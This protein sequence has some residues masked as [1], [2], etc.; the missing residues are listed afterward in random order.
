[1]CGEYSK[2]SDTEGYKVRRWT[3]GGHRV[4]KCV[5]D[6]SGQTARDEAVALQSPPHF[7]SSATT[8]HDMTTHASP[9]LGDHDER[10]A[11]FEADLEALI[12]QKQADLV[13]LKRERNMHASLF[14]LF[15]PEILANIIL[16]V[17][18]EPSYGY[19]HRQINNQS[20]LRILLVCHRFYEIALSTPSL[21]SN[22]VCS[23]GDDWIRLC[24]ARSKDHPL[25]LRR[26]DAHSSKLLVQ[27]REAS[28]TVTD[29]R[30]CASVSPHLKVLT[31]DSRTDVKTGGSFLGGSDI[32]LVH[33][34][35]THVT[36]LQNTPAMPLLRRLTLCSI[37]T[38]GGLSSLIRFIARAPSVEDLFIEGIE[39]KTG[40]ATSIRAQSPIF[41]PHLRTLFLQGRAKHI[42]ACMDLLPLP[43]HSLGVTSTWEKD[44]PDAR[45]DRLHTLCLDFMEHRHQL[46]ESTMQ[47]TYS[48]PTA[49]IITGPLVDRQFFDSHSPS[50]LSMEIG[51]PISA[52]SALLTGVCV[53]QITS[54][55][56]SRYRYMPPTSF[57][58][59][60]STLNALHGVSKLI[61]SEFSGRDTHPILLEIERWVM[62]NTDYLETIELTRCGTGMRGFDN[63]MRT[64]MNV[65]WDFDPYEDGDKYPD[66]DSDGRESSAVP[67]W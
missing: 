17:Q 52:S 60:S 20:W 1:M 43:S 65:E 50:F 41:L 67:V 46:L 5:E 8:S 36:L 27:A 29:S 21:W 18:L 51:L 15:P 32:S 64:L 57:K 61:L 11:S 42:Y 26:G 48:K 12:R 53:V 7:L 9:V 31:L 19:S 10:I 4:C 23:R 59:I 34:A 55:F 56:Y 25:T 37:M 35:L 3:Q 38:T 24:V 62:R 39:V 33:L 66:S 49:Q 40:T 2:R 14:R 16:H 44:F 13:E 28:I 63:R 30:Q 54:A 45:H 22:I 6:H 58:S 47:F